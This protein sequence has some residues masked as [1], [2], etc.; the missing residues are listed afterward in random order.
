M[1]EVF[2]VGCLRV[3]SPN[4][5]SIGF[6]DS[7]IQKT[8]LVIEDAPRLVRLLIVPYRFL[9]NDCVTIR[10]IRAPKLEILGPLLPVV[11]K[12]LVSQGISPVSSANSMR[13]VKIL[14]LRSSGHELD[15]VLNILV[16]FPCLDKLYVTFH[17]HN[18]ENKKNGTQYDPLH[19]IEC[20]QTHLKRVVLRLFVGNEKQ[21]DFARFF[22]LN[23]KVLDKVE[24]QG[25]GDY[26]S[27]SVA[28][29]HSLL[30]VENR[31][32]RDARFEFRRYINTENQLEEH[33]HDLSVADPF[34]SHRED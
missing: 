16:W 33:I 21:Y 22:V 17:K 14:A 26:N 30:Q 9:D 25:F 1:S 18:E 7:T 5:R 11:S 28:Y 34:S 27:V 32:S 24:F 10:V 3:S 13:T 23:A 6:R 12:L 8:E 29:Q 19:P 4:L 31:V 20:L 2:G 15:A